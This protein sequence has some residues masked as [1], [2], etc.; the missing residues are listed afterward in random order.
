MPPSCGLPEDFYKVFAKHL[1]SSPIMSSR[2]R[3][4]EPTHPG[5][6]G[7]GLGLHGDDPHR[8]PPGMGHMAGVHSAGAGM[9]AH[10]PPYPD[11][12][13]NTSSCNS[14]TPSSPGMRG[15]VIER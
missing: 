6:A 4:D 11:S 5:S 15:I 7:I 3:S 13:S 12:S 1:D 9:M 10:N 14:S 2:L 8:Y